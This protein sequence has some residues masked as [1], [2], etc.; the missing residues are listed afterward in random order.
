MLARI[1]SLPGWGVHSPCS[2]PETEKSRSCRLPHKLQYQVYVLKMNQDIKSARLDQRPSACRSDVRTREIAQWV[3]S[4]TIKLDDLSSIPGT[5]M[6][7]EAPTGG[8]LTSI[9][10]TCMFTHIHTCIL[11]NYKSTQTQKKLQNTL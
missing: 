10:A 2:K 4:H 9:S 11:I 8:P 3:K 6:F 5:C 7:A 1:R